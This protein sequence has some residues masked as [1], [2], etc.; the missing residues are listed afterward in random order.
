VISC[1]SDDEFSKGKAE[2]F[3]A[4]RL[5]LEL[6]QQIPPK[7]C[8]VIRRYGLYAHIPQSSGYF[9]FLANIL[10]RCCPV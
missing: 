3:P 9:Q 5:F 6:T 2:A 1:T 8:Q 10:R 7:G 4:M